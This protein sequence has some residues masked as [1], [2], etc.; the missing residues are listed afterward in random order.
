LRE[1]HALLNPITDDQKILRPSLLPSLL[2]NV[3]LNLSH[4]QSRVALYELNKVFQRSDSPVPKESFQAAAVV[5][6]AIQEAAWTFPERPADFYD[7]KGLAESLVQIARLE[8]VKWEYGVLSMP[9][10][11]SESFRVL[12]AA[13]RTLIWGGTLS[14]RVLK[15]FEINSSVTA[16]EFDLSSLGASPCRSVHFLPLPRFP[17]AWRD[18]ALV[19]PDGVTSAQVLAG[20]E[21]LKMPHL[22]SVALF[23]H[24][25]GQGVPEGSRSLAF[26]LKF[27]HGDRT[28]TDIEINDSMTKILTYLKESFSIAIR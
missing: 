8:N 16:V 12:D 5:A 25:R 6:G 17:E 11:S 19:V 26:R 9:Y 14:P 21:S 13:G 2:A 3:K 1:G 23:D 7:A 18:I 20:I 15:S 28:L 4:Q 10:Q 27:R 24:Y 22:V